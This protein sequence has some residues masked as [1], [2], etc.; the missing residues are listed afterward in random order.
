MTDQEKQEQERK[1]AEEKAKQQE[2]LE[3]AYGPEFFGKEKIKIGD[4]AYTYEEI[5]RGDHLKKPDGE[6]SAAQR[7]DPQAGA[8]QQA[9]AAA[10]QGGSQAQPP[11]ATEEQK[12]LVKAIQLKVDTLES[13]YKAMGKNVSAEAVLQRLQ[14]MADEGKKIDLKTPDAI[15]QELLAEEEQ[16]TKDADAEYAK[17]KKAEKQPLGASRG[18]IHDNNPTDKKPVEINN[19][20][21]IIDDF[22]SFRKQ[23]AGTT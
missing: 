5:E 13:T 8:G 20:A 18:P 15:F 11:K 23:K 22:S 3:S 16:K 14:K 17:K 19:E 9:G 2:E 6:G 12:E 4:K 10:A 7:S 21:N 1:E